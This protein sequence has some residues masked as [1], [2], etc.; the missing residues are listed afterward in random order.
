MQSHS[1]AICANPCDVYTPRVRGTRIDTNP[2]DDD[3][4][5]YYALV[6]YKEQHSLW[7]SFAE[8]PADRRVGWFAA[9]RTAL[10]VWIT[11][12]RTGPIYGLRVCARGWQR[13][14]LGQPLGVGELN[15]TC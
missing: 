4:S 13:A 6:N 10:R 7:P 15:G 2:F 11:S 1:P 14:G 5:S 12:N 8:V 3:E 9:K